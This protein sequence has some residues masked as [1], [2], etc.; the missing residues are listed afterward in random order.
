MT[1][2][3]EPSQP[4][5]PLTD[6][7]I[8]TM[9]ADR[10]GRADAA[11]LRGAILAA[12]A[13]QRQGRGW[14]IRPSALMPRTPTAR[15][16]ASGLVTAALL[17]LALAATG[18]RPDTIQ[19]SPPP[20]PTTAPSTIATPAPTPIATP[21]PSLV[22]EPLE[23]DGTP[24]AGHVYTSARFRP[25]VSFQ[26]LDRSLGSGTTDI[27]DVSTSISTIVMKHPKTCI[28]EI[29]L[30]HPDKVECGTIATPLDARSVAQ[31]IID[32]LGPAVQDLGTLATPK[33]VPKGLFAGAYDGRVLI[34]KSV[35]QFEPKA[36]DPDGCRILPA[37]E[38]KDAVVEIRADTP[39]ELVLIDVDGQ[40]VILRIGLKGYDAASTAEA[41]SRGTSGDFSHLL[42]VI[43]DLSF[44]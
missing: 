20:I 11:D 28:E 43:H 14:R 36:D 34:I 40:L 21:S 44:E 9:F 24:T 15:V 16:L 42:L 13:A 33:A 7:A 12:T 25:T 26:V 18:G 22:Y 38:T 31:A 6:A 17:G 5:V 19:P 37:P 29:R 41:T 32:R 39:A 30:M 23:D 8:N 3:R 27:C 1:M 35:R 2:M 4:S 10:A